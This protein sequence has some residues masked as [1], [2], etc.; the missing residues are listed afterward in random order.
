MVGGS[1]L[2]AATDQSPISEIKEEAKAWNLL[3]AGHSCRWLVR[4][5]LILARGVVHFV[6]HLIEETPHAQD[7]DDHARDDRD[8]RVHRWFGH[9]FRWM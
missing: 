2:A 3:P 4:R 9:G 7:T 6:A 8:C 1:T 5:G